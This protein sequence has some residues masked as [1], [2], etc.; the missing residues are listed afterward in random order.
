MHLRQTP[1]YDIS[2][3]FVYEHPP[4]SS[5]QL[6]FYFASILVIINF[7]H[8][9]KIVHRDI[10]PENFIVKENGY[11]ALYNL[12]Y[13]K[14]IKDKTNSIIGNYNYMAP[15][16]I[17]G[18]GYSFEVDYWSA[19][20]IMYECIIGHLPFFGDKNDPMSIYFAIINGKLNFPQNFESKPFEFLI[21]SMLAK[22]P[23]KR[24]A[25]IELIQ[26]HQFFHGF[27]F[28]DVEYLRCNPQYLPTIEDMKGWSSN[29]S[30]KKHSIQLYN[31]WIHDN[32]NMVLN[33][34]ERASSEAWF[35][36]F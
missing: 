19:G 17:M 7:L 2:Q 29:G 26:T 23:S 20:V 9:N 25:K 13:A 36:K 8:K 34:S 31:Q 14:E 22:N 35:E 27:N 28:N 4:F 16:V 6:Q 5:Y 12:R 21:N 18:E 11:L 3:L 30:F 33:D 10:R 1:L 15:E 24:L 32:P